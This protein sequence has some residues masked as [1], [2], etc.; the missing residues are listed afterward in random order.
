MRGDFNHGAK[1]L[2]LRGHPNPNN[3]ADVPEASYKIVLSET[4]T[5]FMG[6]AGRLD[7]K[8]SEAFLSY[9]GSAV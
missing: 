3:V 4:G 5:T 9:R 7:S 6:T 2:S 1:L 8:H